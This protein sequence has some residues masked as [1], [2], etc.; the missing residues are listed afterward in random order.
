MFN[1]KHGAEWR[2]AKEAAAY[3]KSIG[4]R[5]TEATLATLRSNGGG[6]RFSKK[7]GA[8]YY[9]TSTI[10]DWLLEHSSPEVA[11]TSE[12]KALNDKGDE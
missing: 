9:R 5:A 11:S 3:I 4:G 1:D 2:T 8:I 10:D 12:L 7:T 6:P